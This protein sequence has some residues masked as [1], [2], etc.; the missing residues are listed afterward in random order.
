MSEKSNGG[1]PLLR[2]KHL[3]QYFPVGTGLLIDRTVAHVHAVDD[4]S[5]DLDEGQTL[6]LVG[7]SGC[8][9]TTLSRS[10]L[11][12]IEPTEGSVAFQGRDVT[13]MS[14]RKLRPL[15]REM[16]MVFQDP[17]GSLNPRKRISQIVGAPLALHGVDKGEVPGRVRPA[18]PRARS[19]SVDLRH[20]GRRRRRTS[21]ST[22]PG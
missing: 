9:K 1:E 19:T 18:R 20:G 21:W 16:Q 8:G 13:H 4:V 17:F 7:E 12:L 2:V 15:R 3:K 10:L 6:G 14:S 11:R 5:F 22:P